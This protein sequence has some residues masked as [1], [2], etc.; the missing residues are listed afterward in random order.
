VLTFQLSALPLARRGLDLRAMRAWHREWR[1]EALGF[2]VTA[3]I[4]LPLL[5]PI[6]A[7][8]LATGAALLVQETYG[9]AAS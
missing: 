5:T 9:D 8:A 2:G 6:L 7:P 3:L 4:L 1:A